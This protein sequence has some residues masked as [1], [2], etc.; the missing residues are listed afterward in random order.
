MEYLN[1]FLSLLNEMSPYLLL[2][3]LFA[4]L[5]HV[6]VPQRVYTRYLSRN[7]FGSVIWA[8]L[9]GIPL[10]LCSCGVIPTAMSLRNEGASKG[11]TT[12]FLIAT[13]QTGVDS[14]MATYS[15]MGLPFAVIRPIVALLTALA[16]GFFVNKLS[17]AQKHTIATKTND[18][19]KAV[20]VDCDCN[21]SAPKQGSKL[22]KALHYGYVEMLQDIG[23]WLV[24]GLVMAGLIT[25]LLPE[26][27]FEQY[28]DTPF[29]NMLLVLLFSI[30]MYLC[31]TGSIPIAV[32]LMLKGMSP[33]AALVLLM[34]GPA[35]N[36]AA[37][38]VIRKVMGMK[39]LV[40]YLV[41]IVVGA[42]GFGLII[43]FL[44]PDGWFLTPLD[45]TAQACCSTGTPW[46]NVLCSI[47]LMTMLVYAFFLKYKHQPIHT[48]D[49]M[50]K[51]KVNG[52]SCNHCKESVEKNLRKLNGITSVSVDLNSGTASV[53]GTVTEEQVKAVIED[54]GFEYGG[55]E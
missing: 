29:K 8:A 31:A 55:K 32:A 15:L 28:A 45:A 1:A 11:A 36:M 34:A 44:L 4:G 42:I 54:L 43:D 16:G 37:I 51:Y 23:K 49:M 18:E 25:I 38:L 19:G 3:F 35:T 2:G 5:L 46:F 27:F 33:G 12:S 30:P 53:D 7:D 39:T 17:S 10:P 52:M 48:T 6:Y 24:I 40:T 20:E 14:I 22:L 41:T 13:P 26:T 21:T 50:T 47:V 9:F